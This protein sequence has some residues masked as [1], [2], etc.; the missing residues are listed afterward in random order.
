MAPPKLQGDP[1]GLEAMVQQPPDPRVVMGFG[2]GELLHVPGVVPERLAIECLEMRGGNAGQFLQGLYA[3]C[4]L[5]WGEEL[6]G[7]LDADTAEEGVLRWQRASAA[8]AARPP[9]YGARRLD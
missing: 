2:G 4:P 5:D 1:R 7:R 8:H 3:P 6:F 9:P